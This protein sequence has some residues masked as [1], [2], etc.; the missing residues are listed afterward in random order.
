[1]DLSNQRVEPAVAVSD[2]GRARDFYEH[3]LGLRD[4]VEEPGGVRYMCGEGSRLF[5]YESPGTAGRAELTVAGWFVD[6][7]PALMGELRERGITFEHYDQGTPT[8]ESGMFVTHSFRAAWVR[9]PDGN[10][11]AFTEL[12]EVRD[13]KAPSSLPVVHVEVRGA[14]PMRCASSTADSPD[15]SST[16]RPTAQTW[17]P[18][19]RSPGGTGS[20]NGRRPRTAP[21]SRRVSEV[22]PVTRR[23]RSSTSECPT[24]RP[25]WHGP[26]SR[27]ARW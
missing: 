22:G 5:V 15:G 7:L 17:W 11:L 1:M 16:T 4:P 6:D 25:L 23:T 20:S 13:E 18:R 10:T 2:L 26:K 9:D 12:I 3:R 21:A 14:D 24:C 27:V 8:D 19:S